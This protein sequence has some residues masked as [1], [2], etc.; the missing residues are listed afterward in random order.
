MINGA[1]RTALTHGHLLRNLEFFTHLS[2]L[3]FLDLLVTST[4]AHAVVSG[5]DNALSWGS[6]S[7]VIEILRGRPASKSKLG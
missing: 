5:P 4:N 7:T 3:D 2:L 1:I 6:S